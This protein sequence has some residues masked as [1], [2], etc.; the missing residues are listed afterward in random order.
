MFTQHGASLLGRSHSRAPL[1]LAEAPVGPPS[2]GL[3]PFPHAGLLPSLPQVVIPSA[4]SRRHL[5]LSTLTLLPGEPNQG[6]ITGFSLF[7]LLLSTARIIWVQPANH[8]VEPL[9]VPKTFEKT[10][11]P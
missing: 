10:V 3:L 6:P 7:F 11:F 8:P 5:G 2:L 4:S 1:G 9:L